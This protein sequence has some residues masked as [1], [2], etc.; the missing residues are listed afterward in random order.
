MNNQTLNYGMDIRQKTGTYHLSDTRKKNLRLVE[1]SLKKQKA[2]SREE[3]IAQYQRNHKQST[4]EKKSEEIR[5]QS[6][7][8]ANTIED[9]VNYLQFVSNFDLDK[10]SQYL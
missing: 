4:A 6:M 7:N 8:P 1:E 5:K 9:D 2:F 10:S 3:M